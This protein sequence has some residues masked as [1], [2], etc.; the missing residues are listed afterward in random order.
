MRQKSDEFFKFFNEF[1]AQVVN[2]LPK[3]QAPPKGKMGGA[4]AKS[5]V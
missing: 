2:V 4:G 3:V 5:S 1:F